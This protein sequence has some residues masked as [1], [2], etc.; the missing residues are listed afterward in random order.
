MRPAPATASPTI[1]HPRDS[2]SSVTGAYPEVQSGDLAP[3]MVA[4][5]EAAASDALRAWIDANAPAPA[6]PDWIYGDADTATFLAP[7]TIAEMR[8][9]IADCDWQDIEPDEIAELE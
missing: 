1:C 3:D 2:S 8:A 9:W 7:E 6:R 4:R 5:L